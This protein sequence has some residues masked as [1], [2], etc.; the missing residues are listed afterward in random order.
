[1]K[2]NLKIFG[3]FFFCI[4]LFIACTTEENPLALSKDNVYTTETG[5]TAAVNGVYD[6]LGDYFSLQFIYH[7][8]MN[9]TSGSFIGHN[10]R[11]GLSNMDITGGYNHLNTYYQSTYK[12]IA[13]ANEVIANVAADETNLYILNQLGQ[14]HFLRAY[15]YFNLVRTYGGLPLFLEPASLETL[16]KP[17]SSVEDVYG[18]IIADLENAKSLLYGAG[19]QEIGRPTNA[20]A[21]FLLAKV[22]MT[23]AGDDNGSEYWQMAYNNAIEVYGQYTLVADY[24]DLFSGDAGLANNNSESIF[25]LQIN[26]ESHT[27]SYFQMFSPNKYGAYKGW[28]RVKP[29]AEV[30]DSHYDAYP[31]DP[32]ID[33]TYLDEYTEFPKYTRTRYTYPNP[34]ITPDKRNANWGFPF[35]FKFTNKDRSLTSNAT[36]INF[37]IYRYAELLLMLGEIENE[38]GQTASAMTRV[39]EVLTRARN[40]DPSGTPSAEPADWTGL[41][42]E[43]FREAI[44]YEYRFELL[45]EGQDFFTNRRRGWDWFRTNIILKHNNYVNFKDGVD[46]VYPDDVKMMLLPFPSNE[47]NTN[48]LIGVEDQNP[49]Y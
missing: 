10:D 15:F 4:S 19:L 13:R 22:Y 39:N 30:V 32:R 37:T 18:A 20:A 23:M 21:S 36:N 43:E 33:A 14:T 26:T 48:N 7:Q 42:Q 31:T 11:S 2:T 40:S 41:S 47:I 9:N 27:S 34:N 35:I 46:L 49:G 12:S 8:L 1:M 5:M 38:L 44:M 25:E 16:H 17:R 29:N 45:A 3:L 24:N 6:G 28:R